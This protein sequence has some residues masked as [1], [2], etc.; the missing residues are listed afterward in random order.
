[1][2]SIA[3]RGDHVVANPRSRLGD[4]A[5]NAVI[6]TTGKLNEHGALPGADATTVELRRALAGQE[7]TCRSL[8]DALA[9][10]AIGRQTAWSHDAVGLAATLGGLYVDARTKQVVR[11]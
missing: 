3:V 4:H 2:L 5:N 10:E 1:V 9:D 8:T 6:T 11:R 7:P